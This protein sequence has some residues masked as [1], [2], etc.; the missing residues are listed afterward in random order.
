MPHK[1]TVQILVVA[2]ASLA[3]VASAVWLLT[4]Q[5]QGPRPLTQANAAVQ[6]TP[7]AMHVTLAEAVSQ[8]FAPHIDAFGTIEANPRALS[9]V[10][11]PAELIVQRV[12][13][14]PGQSVAAGQ[15]LLEVALSPDSQLFAGLA[16]QD[17]HAAEKALAAVQMRFGAHLATLQE[18]LSA[19]AN[20]ATTQ[21]KLARALQAKVPSAGLVRATEAGTVRVIAAVAGGV[22]PAGSPLV[23]LTR[24]AAVG[25]DLARAEVGVDPLEA[26]TLQGGEAVS[27]RS[28]DGDMSVFTGQ[29]DLIQPSIDTTSRL[30]RVSVRLTSSSVPAVGTPIRAH[31][32]LPN[33]AG[34][35]IPR[36][37][38]LPTADGNA[39]FVVSKGVASRRF[40]R[41]CGREGDTVC[42]SSGIDAGDSIAISGV[43]DLTDGASVIAL[44][45]NP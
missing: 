18:K 7:S 33:R 29:I 19:E 4:R 23:T 24:G 3:L 9:S 37:A 8:P 16:N 30:R 35:I 21:T 14:V 32:V 42:I 45:A 38:L 20:L 5:S 25:A 43:A 11:W 17:V 10:A 40:V 28:T 22:A 36:T 41:L 44:Q 39:V 13:V 34:L 15:P 31:I 6:V 1:R 2:A 12:L 27:I 26:N